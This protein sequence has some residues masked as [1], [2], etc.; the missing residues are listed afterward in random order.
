MPETTANAFRK[1]L[2]TD[3]DQCIANH[4][5]LTVKRRNGGN[6]VVIGEADWKA[7]EETVYLS[8]VP[9]LVASIQSAAK[10]PLAE[11]TK[12]EDLEW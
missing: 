6:F 7:I 9:G 10:E 1:N 11:G 4:D 2:K 12:L 5:V 3:V 8:N